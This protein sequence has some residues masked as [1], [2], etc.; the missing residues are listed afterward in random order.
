MYC[1]ESALK[2][3]H[4]RKE[5]TDFISECVQSQAQKIHKDFWV[6]VRVFLLG[7]SLLIQK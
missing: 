6:P 2:V 5:L 7:T 4:C 3:A 1:L